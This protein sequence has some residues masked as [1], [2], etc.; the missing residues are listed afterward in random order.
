MKR[1]ITFFIVIFAF[2]L[3]IGKLFPNTEA[4]N[5]LPMYEGISKND[6]QKKA[7]NE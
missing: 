6:L 1:I 5:T 4:I 3:M 2:I 7:D